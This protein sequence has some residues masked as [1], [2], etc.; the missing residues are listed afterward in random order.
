M[1][2][3]L[4]DALDRVARVEEEVGRLDA[5]RALRLREDVILGAIIN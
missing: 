1:R 3:E 5:V 4:V 2:E